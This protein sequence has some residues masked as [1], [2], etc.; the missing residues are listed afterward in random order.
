[1]KIA[2][3]MDPI[4][5]IDFKKDSTLLLIYEAQKRNHDVFYIESKNLFFDSPT[6]AKTEKPPWAFATLLINS[7]IKTVFP[8][9]APPNN[10]IFP[11]FA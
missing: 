11:P 2:V 3:V 4:S 7:I 1:M 9:P 10:P 5:D 8:T 6:P